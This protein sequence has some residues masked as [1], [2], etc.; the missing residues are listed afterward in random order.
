M[1]KALKRVLQNFPFFNNILYNQRTYI[2]IQSINCYVA[3]KWRFQSKVL[4][5]MKIWVWVQDISMTV[6]ETKLRVTKRQHF[7][8]KY[9]TVSNNL[10]SPN[11][12]SKNFL[13]KLLLSLQPLNFKHQTPFNVTA[14][15]PFYWFLA[16]VFE[17]EI[18]LSASEINIFRDFNLIYRIYKSS[19]R[20]WK[21]SSQLPARNF[22][23]PFS[24]VNIPWENHVK[25]KWRRQNVVYGDK[26]TIV[27]KTDFSFSN[28]H[29]L[30]ED[31]GEFL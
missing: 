21:S 3:T 19:K 25:S 9:C 5:H 17:L 2:D 8:S 30:S 18:F 22:L 7:Q 29:S 12:Q 27:T 15:N 1:L 10:T 14:L 20:G 24:L 23:F 13:R 31:S 28:T 11:T 26:H 6:S 16:K 4:T